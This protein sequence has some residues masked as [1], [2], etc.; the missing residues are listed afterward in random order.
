[1]QTDTDMP[2]AGRREWAAMAIL[3]LPCLLYSMDLTVLN[4]ALPE[5]STALQPSA[6]ELL[7]MVDIYGFVLAAALI[8]MGVY[9]D[10]IGRRRLLLW[11]A[12]A[13]GAA[14]LFAAFA[15]SPAMMIL[16][17]A[18][19]G[20]AAA[21][22]AP[23]TL[24]MISNLFPHEED[25]RRAIGV[26]IASFSAG[27]ALGPLIG[28]VL[29]QYFW[30]GSVFLINLPVM[31]LLLVLGPKLLPE[32]RDPSAVRPDTAS[33]LCLLLAVLGLV[34]A[35]KHVAANGWTVD[36]AAALALSLLAGTTFFHRQRRLTV[37]F[38]DLSLFSSLRFSVALTLNV[39]GF[40]VA[41][42]MF[43]LIALYFQ[44][45]LGLSQLEAGLAAAPSGVAFVLGALI[46][47]ALV[48]R[49]GV[50]G[51]MAG[52]LLIAACGFAT[53]GIAAGNAG[54]W[55]MIGGYCLFSLGLAPTFTMTT[56]VIVGSVPAS[57]AGAAAGLSEASTELGGAFG[58][59]VLGSLTTLLYRTALA[60]EPLLA[61]LP[62]GAGAESELGR[63]A[64]R[65]AVET[66]AM[67]S[68]AVAALGALLCLF[69][70]D[71]SR[72]RSVT[73]DA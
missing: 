8:P 21:T 54:L 48:P 68:S 44:L 31:V 11:G 46:A 57:E 43:L 41:F 37:P 71:G 23:S 32:A 35:M 13:F 12:F 17:R 29:L 61:G 39:L 24:S 25:R 53:A 6:T 50:A 2:R 20:L 16:A 4:L 63:A 45:A 30:W 22:L 64:F 67:V 38:L 62:I 70:R 28:G 10:R 19:M 42:G 73:E 9:G 33:A 34:Y 55:L 27:G 36:A 15:Q 65:Q 58:I 51:L 14:S 66:A 59:A 5:L 47:P 1:M 26:W 72:A 40:F 3:A 56:D 49:F 69:I 52:G 18:S 7:W 60:N